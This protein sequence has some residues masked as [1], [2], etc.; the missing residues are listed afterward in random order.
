MQKTSSGSPI[1][2]ELLNGGFEKEVITTVYGPAGSGKSNIAMIATASVIKQGKNVI[3]IDTEG[4]FSAERMKQLLPYDYER[5]MQNII[6]LKPISFDEQK[7]HFAKLNGAVDKDRIG[8]IVVDSIT[9]LYRLEKGSDE[10]IRTTNKELAK[11]LSQLSEIARKKDI[12]ILVT[13]QVYADFKKEN[14]FHMVGGDLLK[15]WSKDIVKLEFEN[16]YRRAEI[17]KHRSI[18]ERKCITFEISNS[19]IYPVQQRKKFSLF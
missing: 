12:P 16:N 11:Q 10:E 14:S 8:L 4:G 9:M 5:I 7:K 6:L 17:V 18:P 3:Y 2:D 1:L 19:G 15:Y 13:N